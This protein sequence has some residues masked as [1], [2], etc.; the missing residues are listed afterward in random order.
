MKMIHKKD[1]TDYFDIKESEIKLIDWAPYA[2]SF[3]VGP[4]DYLPID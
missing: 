4:L 1:G 2:E 3:V